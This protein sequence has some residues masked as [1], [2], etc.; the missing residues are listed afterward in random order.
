MGPAGRHE[1]FG[2]DE[3]M[4]AFFKLHRDLPREGPGEAA[5]VAWA[6]K[7]AGLPTDAMICD[8]AC[9]PGADI[10]DLLS[11]APEGFV[12]G[13]EKQAHF[14]AA[15][16]ARYAASDR[17]R[18]E[19]GDLGRIGG[20][21]DMIWCAGALYFLGTQAGLRLWRKS[22]KPGGTIAFSAPCY[23]TSNPGADAIAFWEGD[24]AFTK[25][26]LATQIG[27]AGFTL[28]GTRTLSDAA[29][30]AY[31]QPMEARIATLMPTADDELCTTLNEGLAEA[32]AWR[33]VK[34]QTGY[35]L[36][37]VRAI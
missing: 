6:A 18:I 29:W 22:L 20:P 23:F 25:P 21:Y 5:D 31:Y 36:C 11:V 37:V 3:D 2:Q 1:F 10:G 13:I 8:A 15:A 17:V 26:A 33:A 19:Q 27:M 14:V 4:S 9:G 34:D 12:T 24:P 16:Q 28:I 32:A 7:T 35:L 30:E